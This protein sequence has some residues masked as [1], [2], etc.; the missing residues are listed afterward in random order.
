VTSGPARVVLHIGAMKTGTTYLQR[1]LYANEPLLAGRGVGLAGRRWADQVAGAR[2]LT[3]DRAHVDPPAPGSWDR[4]VEATRA[5]GTE[6]AVISMEFLSFADPAAAARAVA[7]FDGAEVTV[8]L[9]ARSLGRMVPSLWQE[10]A[11]VGGALG[12]DAYVAALAAP[13]ARTLPR[14][15]DLWLPLD[16]PRMVEHWQAAGPQ[17]VVLVTVPSR[18]DRNALWHRFAGVLGVPADGMVEKVR[19]NESL[20]RTSAELMVRLQ[21][22]NRRAGVPLAVRR[23]LKER[24]AQQVLTSRRDQEPAVVLPPRFEGWAARQSATLVD[25]LRRLGPEVVGDLDELLDAAPG[26][27]ARWRR[28]GR[29]PSAEE[30]TDGELLEVALAG[31]VGL[32]EQLAEQSGAG[33]PG[34]G[35]RSRRSDAFPG[36][37]EHR[38]EEQRPEA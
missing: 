35:R 27:G 25:E 14:A 34:R 37:D 8:V 21:R 5:L 20:G 15:R 9:T 4:L 3:G 31:L 10:R 38:A 24:L 30:P 36:S 13:G 26:D 23:V 1:L 16:L 19:R 22:E 33:R 17:R 28:P 2:E 7:S 32:A 29:G 12:L 18:T 6:T 11:K